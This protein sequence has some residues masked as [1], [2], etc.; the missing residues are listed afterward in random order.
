MPVCWS[1]TQLQLFHSWTYLGIGLLTQLLLHWIHVLA[2]LHRQAGSP[3]PV[4]VLKPGRAAV[5]LCAG[6]STVWCRC[7]PFTLET[8]ASETAVRQHL[9]LSS[10]RALRA[11]PAGPKYQQIQQAVVNSS[12]SQS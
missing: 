3:S 4:L 9:F 8:A 6:T 11:A 10:T 12:S 5:A 1:W 2:W 7:E